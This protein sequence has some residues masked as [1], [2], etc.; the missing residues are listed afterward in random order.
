MSRSSVLN[1][2]AAVATDSTRKPAMATPASSAARCRVVQAWSEA[3]ALS[4]STS[5]LCPWSQRGFCTGS[6]STA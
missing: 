1:R 2:E 3:V 6:P 5:S 4:V